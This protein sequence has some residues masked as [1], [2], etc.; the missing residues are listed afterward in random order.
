MYKKRNN[1]KCGT[2]SAS[3]LNIKTDNIFT[4][5]SNYVT[6]DNGIVISWL[7]PSTPINLEIDTVIRSMVTKCI[8]TASTKIGFNKYYGDTFNLKVSSD[9]EKIYFKLTLIKKR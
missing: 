8:V 9:N 7:T 3:F 6:L 5:I 4:D 1:R 2:C